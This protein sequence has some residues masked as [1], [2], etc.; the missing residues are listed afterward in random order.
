MAPTVEGIQACREEL[1]QMWT[2][3]E[4]G[5]R[6]PWPE[7]L[8]EEQ[9]LIARGAED[10]LSADHFDLYH[11][12]NWMDTYRRSLDMTLKILSS[13]DADW[14]ADWT[15]AHPGLVPTDII[16]RKPGRPRIHQQ[17][18]Q[19]VRVSLPVDLIAAIDAATDNRTAYIERAIRAALA[20]SQEPGAE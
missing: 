14:L 4:D 11:I 2:G 15:A 16:R 18:R 7:M 19:D 17:P 20:T 8:A 13:Y 3:R 9:R 10:E 5:T 1:E 12:Q 6:E